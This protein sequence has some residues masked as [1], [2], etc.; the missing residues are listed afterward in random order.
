MLPNYESIHFLVLCKPGWFPN[1][2][3]DYPVTTADCDGGSGQ[4]GNPRLRYCSQRVVAV[5][6]ESKGPV[7][8]SEMIELPN[9][10]IHAMPYQCFCYIVYTFTISIADPSCLFYEV[11]TQSK[12]PGLAVNL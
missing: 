7:E 11:C 5:Q 12:N 4:S 2:G 8:F 9:G 10:N 6:V 3:L 1:S